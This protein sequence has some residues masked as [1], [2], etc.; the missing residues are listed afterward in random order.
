MEVDIRVV[1]EAAT[2]VVAADTVAVA[3]AKPMC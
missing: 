1:E 3:I 2:L